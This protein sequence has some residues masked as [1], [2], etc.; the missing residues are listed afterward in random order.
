MQGLSHATT[1]KLEVIIIKDLIDHVKS[2]NLTVLEPTTNRTLKVHIPSAYFKDLVFDFDYDALLNQ[3]VVNYNLPKADIKK[4]RYED[5]IAKR[6]FFLDERLLDY[7]IQHLPVH[8]LELY[9][10]KDAYWPF[11]IIDG[12]ENTADGLM[13]VSLENKNFYVRDDYLRK[14][15]GLDK[16]SI[17]HKY[18]SKEVEL[19]D[20]QIKPDLQLFGRVI[21]RGTTTKVMTQKDL[22]QEQINVL[23][24]FLAME[25]KIETQIQNLIQERM[26]NF[27]YLTK[28][29]IEYM[30]KFN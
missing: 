30:L 18:V 20:V 22:N 24:H 25:I 11:E 29:D 13:E 9:S 4:I 3:M 5:H 19:V 14:E 6:T 26:K 7:Q 12:F 15:V 1:K 8:R 28:T 10:K 21:K 2:K 16:E 27:S 17:K 23:N